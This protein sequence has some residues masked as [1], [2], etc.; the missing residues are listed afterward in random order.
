M[1][2]GELYNPGEETLVAARKAAQLL[3]AKYNATTFSDSTLRGQL[4]Q[5][6][7]GSFGGSLAIRAPF[8]VDYGKNIHFGTDVFLN[9]G[10][11]FLDICPIRIGDRTQIGPNVHIYAADHPRDITARASGLEFGKPV[12]IGSDVWIGG[13]AV[14]LPGIEIGDGAIVAAGSIVTRNVAAGETVRGNPARP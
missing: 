4:L 10:C 7:L 8:Y 2:A 3:M 5:D 1:S 6:L 9:Y 14:I 13:S 12:R 11:V